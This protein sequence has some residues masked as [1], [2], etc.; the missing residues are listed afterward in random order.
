MQFQNKMS[1]N[2]DYDN[3]DYDDQC[4]I[5]SNINIDYITCNY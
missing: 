2:S 1:G 5:N 3:N 4:N